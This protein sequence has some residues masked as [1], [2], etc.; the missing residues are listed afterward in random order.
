MQSNGLDTDVSYKIIIDF[1]TTAIIPAANVFEHMFRTHS[2]IKDIPYDEVYEPYWLSAPAYLQAAYFG[3]C[4]L[5]IGC[6]TDS[7]RD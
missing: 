1:E 6:W 7:H 4:L 5:S 3:K 2:V